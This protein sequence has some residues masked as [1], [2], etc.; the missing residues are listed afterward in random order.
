[1][2]QL[3]KSNHSGE[4]QVTIEPTLPH[5]ECGVFAAGRPMFVEGPE[6]GDQGMVRIAKTVSNVI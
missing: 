1:M 5:Y 2:V 4:H 3:S 6:V